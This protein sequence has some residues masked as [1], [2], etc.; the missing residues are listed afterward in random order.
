M[1]FIL[2]LGLSPE[3]LEKVFLA[4]NGLIAGFSPYRGTNLS[5]IHYV[6]SSSWAA[7]GPVRDNT[8]SCHSVSC[9]F[10]SLLLC[11]S[12]FHMQFVI[13]QQIHQVTA[14][15]LF[16]PYIECLYQNAAPSL[17]SLL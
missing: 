4:C 7:S 12:L 14:W 15:H 3:R 16:S 2:P 6:L 11:R 17:W 13:L 9:F 5:D 10:V 8:C 1:D